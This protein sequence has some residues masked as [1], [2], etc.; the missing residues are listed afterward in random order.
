MKTEVWIK[1][2]AKKKYTS[3]VA[4][5]ISASKKKPNTAEDEVVLKLDLEIPDSLFEQPVFQASVKLPDIKP[6]FPDKLEISSHLEKEMT[7]KFGFKI[8]VDM[9]ESG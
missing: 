3:W 1:V 8:K 7:K 5:V 9:V 6:A 2:K 4:S